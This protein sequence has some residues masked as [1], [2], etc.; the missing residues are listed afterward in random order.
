MTVH[1]EA[2]SESWLALPA[3]TNW[4]GPRTASS[5]ANP[6]NVVFGRL[7]SSRSRVTCFSLTSPVS[8]SLT[9]I[10]ASKG[11]ISSS[12]LP[13][14]WAAAVRCWEISAYSSCASRLTLTLGDN[15]GRFDH[16]QVQFRLVLHQP[17]VSS[18][19]AIKFVV[20]NQGDGL[21]ATSHDGRY[22]LRHHAL[23]SNSNGLQAGAAE[24]V[25]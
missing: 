21:Y 8:L 10:V 5:D 13:D 15:I 14:C 11:T 16:R 3:V 12:N 9:S 19:E 7:H 20:L 1:T 6:S 24:P 23:R 22:L 4:P 18:T 17:F 25:N 2:P